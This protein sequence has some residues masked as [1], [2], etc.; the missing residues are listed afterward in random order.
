MGFKLS[1]KLASTP[2]FPI[3]QIPLPLLSAFVAMIDEQS[4][5]DKNYHPYG[6]KTLKL[7]SQWPVR[8]FWQNK[9][10]KQHGTADH[11]NVM[12]FDE[13]YH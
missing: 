5:G 4:N 8:F 12:L 2:S 13:I 7:L 10:D 1:V 3:L 11:E 9:K 6:K